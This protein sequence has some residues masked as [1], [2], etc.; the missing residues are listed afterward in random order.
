MPFRPLAECL[1][2]Q[3]WSSDTSSPRRTRRSRES[4][5]ASPLGDQRGLC[6]FYEAR[7]MRD[8]LGSIRRPRN[9]LCC[10]SAP[11]SFSQNPL[12]LELSPPDASRF[13]PVYLCLN[14]PA[15]LDPDS[16]YPFEFSPAPRAIDTLKA[17]E[18]ANTPTDRDGL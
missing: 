3:T 8:I 4:S 11:W 10:F 16:G 12:D 17:G 18:F 14:Q 15:T 2:R 7:A 5:C 9:G 6:R 13:V 1:T